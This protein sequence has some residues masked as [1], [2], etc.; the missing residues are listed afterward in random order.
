MN[1]IRISKLDAARRQL[2]AAL[3]LYFEDGDT[4]AIHTLA[5]V[6]HEIL[7]VL[8]RKKGGATMLDW[9]KALVTPEFEKQLIDWARQPQN[10]FKHGGKDANSNIEFDTKL[11]EFFLFDACLAYGKVEAIPKGDITAEATRI[12]I[13]YLTWYLLHR[14]T[15]LRPDSDLARMVSAFEPYKHGT[16]SDYLKQIR[17]AR[18]DWSGPSDTTV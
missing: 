7:S 4:V 11:T 18:H 5:A 10:F 3:Q 1:M 12:Q 6:A 17:L 16:R 2:F 15:A 9:V 14:P 8:V 13:A